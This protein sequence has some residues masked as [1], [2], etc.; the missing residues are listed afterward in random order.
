MGLDDEY[1]YNYNLKPIFI[2]YFQIH[3]HLPLSKAYKRQSN[4][5]YLSPAF[6]EG[7]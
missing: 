1:H 6:E 3:S 5:P 4:F 2:E 7:W